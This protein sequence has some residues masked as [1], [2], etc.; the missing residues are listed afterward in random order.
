MK[1]YI[2]LILMGFTLCFTLISC[3]SKSA[4][5]QSNATQKITSDKII[6]NH[7]NNKKDFSTLYIKANAKY[8][9]ENQSQSVTAEIRIKKNEAILVSIRF[10]GITMAKALIT[11]DKVQ[12]YEKIGGKY[13]DGDYAALSQFLGSDLD[14]NKVQNLFIGQA[15]DDLKQDKY[16]N[17]IEE[18]M[19]KLENFLDANN[20]KTFYFE[21]DKFLIKKEEIS[22]TEKQRMLQVIYPNYKEYPLASLPEAVQIEAVQEKGKTNI[23]IDYNSVTFNEELSFPYSVPEGYERIFIN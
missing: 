16:K 2:K 5:T 7:Y 15:L 10:L 3:K 4:V 23:N 13:F 18:K 19:Y 8:K 12:Y 6:E 14:F 1:S 17:S 22:Q 9:D 11:P 21:S 20:K